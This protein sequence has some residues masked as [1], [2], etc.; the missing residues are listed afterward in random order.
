M[1]NRLLMVQVVSY[2][3]SDDYMFTKGLPKLR[4]YLTTRFPEM[5]SYMKKEIF[6]LPPI[7]ENMPRI[8]WWKCGNVAGSFIASN[9]ETPTTVMEPIDSYEPLLAELMKAKKEGN[10]YTHVGFS[11]FI[12]SFSKFV[13]WAKSVKEFDPAII[14]IAGNVGAL[15]EDTEKYVDYV[16]KGDGIPFLRSLLGENGIPYKLS[17]ISSPIEIESLGLTF[18]IDQLMLTTKLGCPNKC[19]F[20]IT[21]QLFSGD[22]RPSFA[23]PQEVYEC[24]T[25]YYKKTKKDFPI[26]MSEPTAIVSHK[27]WYE[28]FELFENEPIEYRITMATTL[29]SLQSFDFDRIASSSLLFGFFLIGIESFTNKYSKNPKFEKTKELI[30]DLNKRGIGSVGTFMIGFEHQ[31]RVMIWDEIRQLLELDLTEQ[32]VLNLQPLPATPLWTKLK[33]EGR[34]LD[35]PKSFYYINGFQT[36]Q[37]PHFR[38]GFVDMLPLIY[39]INKYL[40]R[41]G[42]GRIIGTIKLLRNVI[43]R[44]EAFGEKGDKILKSIKRRLRFYEKIAMHAFDSWKHCVNPSQENIGNY[45]EVLKKH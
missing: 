14:T 4:E 11:V 36:F 43:K 3:S 1:K 12:A 25:N 28:L 22:F 8:N 34:L 6:E 19:D 42:S 2:V 7:W 35:I 32:R 24:I 40:L 39:E 15:F 26:V 17:S 5:D 37:H 27:W 23:T 10:P 41:E 44:R 29:S 21:H 31:D 33:D 16:C 20:C 9:L 45:L 18:N 30:K 38:P 13:E